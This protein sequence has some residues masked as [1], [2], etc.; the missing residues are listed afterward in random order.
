MKSLLIPNIIILSLLIL[1]S[2]ENLYA[3]HVI[4]VR[5]KGPDFETF[6]KYFKAEFEDNTTFDSIIIDKK[7]NLESVL[8]GKHKKAHLMLL[9]DNTAIN[10]AKEMIKEKH[11]LPPM[12][13]AMALNINFVLKDTPQIAGVGFEVSGYSLING[14]NQLISTKIQRVKVIYRQE[15][16]HEVVQDSKEYLK[17]ENIELISFGIKSK[18]AAEINK[19]VKREI[20]KSSREAEALWILLDNKLINKE[21]FSKTWVFESRQQKIP[22]VCGVEKFALPPISM[23]SFAAF[24]EIKGLATHV[25]DMSLSIIEGESSPEDYG[26]EY[27]VSLKKI[28]NKSIMKGLGIKL[29][30]NKVGSDGLKIINN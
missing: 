15:I 16:F 4:I 1:A 6:E 10:K 28:F 29:K 23:C 18:N 26:V 17:R 27:I 2:I 11:K 5:A 13:A 8:N 20:K 12:V 19:V 21:N 7:T 22:F 14:L 25:A 9:L 3:T 30:N 24:P